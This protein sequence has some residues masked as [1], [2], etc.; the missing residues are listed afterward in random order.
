MANGILTADG[1]LNMEVARQL[2]WKLKEAELAI[3]K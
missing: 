1:K 3:V 2:G